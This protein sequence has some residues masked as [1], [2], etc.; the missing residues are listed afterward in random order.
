MTIIVGSNYMYTHTQLNAH[1]RRS[2]EERVKICSRSH[3][4]TQLPNGLKLTFLI[5]LMLKECFCFVF[6]TPTLHRYNPYPGRYT[7]L[8]THNTVRALQ[9]P[10][11]VYN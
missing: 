8:F 6:F 2:S 4:S 11:I 9:S 10:K 7:L 5:S 3:L 1:V